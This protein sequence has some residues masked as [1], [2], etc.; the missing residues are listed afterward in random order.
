MLFSGRDRCV[1]QE[2]YDD[3]LRKAEKGRLIR[4]ARA[5]A[6]GGERVHR[7]VLKQ[8]R[9]L[10]SRAAGEARSALGTLEV[11]RSLLPANRPPENAEMLGGTHNE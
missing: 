6:A 5:G 11:K 2:Q 8:I 3:M 10:T 7:K 1:R 9:K 4:E